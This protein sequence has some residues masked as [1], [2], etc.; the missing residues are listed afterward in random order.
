MEGGMRRTLLLATTALATGIGAPAWAQDLGFALDPILLG[1]ALR[2]DRA[3]LDTPVAASIVEGEALERQQGTD[4]QQLIGSTPGLTIDGGPRAISQ[5]PNIRGFRD[6][7]IVLRFDGGRLNFGQA[8]RGRFFI[9]PALV[10]RVEVVRGGGSTLFGSGALGGVISV[11]TVDAAD[12]LAPGRTMG[13]RL[14]FGFASNGDQP[15]AAGTVFAD[16]GTTDVLLSLAGRR[17][18]SDLVSGDGTEIPFSQYESLN[19]LFKFGFEPNADSRF[20]LSYSAYRDEGQVPANSSSNPDASNPVVDREADVQDLRLSWDYAP[21]GSDWIDLTALFYATRIDIEE[22][23]IPP[24]AARL[25]TTRYDT[26][27]L[28]IVNRST[29]DLG[30]PVD[31]VYGI[32]AFRDTQ[33]GDRDGAP[34]LA[35][36]DAEATTLGVFA[37]ATL[38]LSDRLDLIAGIR[39]DSYERDPDGP[40]LDSV[41]EDFFSPRLGLSFRPTDSWQVFGNVAQAFRAPSLSELYNSGLHFAGVRRPPPRPGA[42]PIVIFPDNFFVPNPDLE[43]ERSTQFELGTRFDRVGV[44]S[45][46]DR[47]SFSANAYYASVEDY[48]EQTVDI[49]AGTTSSANVASATL[50]GFEAEVDYDAQNWFVGAGLT[51]PRGENDAGGWLGSI[52]QDRLTLVG[53][54][55]PWDEW[56]FG[57]RA[58]VASDQTRVPESGTPSDGYQVVDLFASY[59]PDSGMLAGGTIRF[60]VD[61]VFDEQY[62]IYPNGLPQ[63]GRSIKLSAAFT[64]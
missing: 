40:G 5:E 17:T 54:I 38:D 36:P 55:R 14:S 25:D 41:S 28:E 18:T 34:R 10:Q 51:I 49:R 39:A 32:E 19:G 8:H 29:F 57:A 22:S 16:Y 63:Q 24:A 23:V 46:D 11:E 13:A 61:N 33:E 26:Y 6:E 3:L 44:F 15:S 56:E 35:F 12:L 2:D 20:E 48:I 64:F 4:F 52:P 58:T 7:Q 47:L 30:V 45:G 31:I 9:D 21:E 42:P 43:P 37:E 62:T 27:G 59:M 50:W 53:G 1:S 60:G